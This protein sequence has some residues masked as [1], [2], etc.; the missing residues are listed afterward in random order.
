MGPVL[1]G[2]LL[3]AALFLGWLSGEGPRDSPQDVPYSSFLEAV[4]QGAIESVA[5]SPEALTWR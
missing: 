5:I 3:M 1:I 2:A 4:D